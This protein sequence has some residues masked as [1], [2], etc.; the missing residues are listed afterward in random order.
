MKFYAH[1]V[2]HCVTWDQ[3][4]QW[5]ENDRRAYEERI[6]ILLNGFT[7]EQDR[8]ARIMQQH[9]R[10][11][12]ATR[13]LTLILQ[14]QK[15][16]SSAELKFQTEPHSIEALCNYTLQT[17]VGE[18]N[19]AKAELLYQDCLNRMAARGGDHAFILYGY[20]IFLAGETNRDDYW[21]FAERGRRAEERYRQRKGRND[22]NTTT[23][24]S[25]LY[26]VSNEYYRL[27]AMEQPRSAQA[28]HNYALCRMIAFDDVQGASAAFK[29]A[30]RR[31]PT[32]R[33]ILENFNDMLYRQAQE[34]MGNVAV[35]GNDDSNSVNGKSKK[36]SLFDVYDLY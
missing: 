19:V 21:S 2:T 36:L 12:V 10:A 32:N 34:K 35:A 6:S 25:S 26:L 27:M 7:V 8:A 24:S 31:D 18:R 20:A 16:M 1:K 28:W 13:H 29:K 30:L 3:P 9:W 5:Q 11:R 17:H 33:R 15:I 23:T 22:S 4:K 14:A